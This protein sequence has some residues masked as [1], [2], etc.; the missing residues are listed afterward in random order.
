VVGTWVSR[1]ARRARLVVTDGT[2]QGRIISLRRGELL[3]GRATASGVVLT[4]AGVSRTH[5][6]VRHEPNGTWLMDLGTLSGTTVNGRRIDGPT[7]L[8][9]GDELCFGGEARMIYL[10]PVPSRRGMLPRAVRRRP[11]P[12]R[13]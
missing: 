7:Q 9:G 2:A 3:I 1:T 8:S 11:W 13:G 6:C 4:E 12:A 5:A 10:E